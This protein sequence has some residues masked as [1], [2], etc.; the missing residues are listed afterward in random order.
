MTTAWVLGSGGL[1][2]TALCRALRGQRVALFVPAERFCWGDCAVLDLQIASAMRG[3]A[4][5]INAGD[6]WQIYWAAGI[7]TMGST[8]EAVSTETRALK[9]LLQ[10][11]ESYPHLLSGSGAIA[12]A[13]SAGAVYAGA[14]DAVIT[15]NTSA[16]P[17]T[18][19]ACE[20]V[21]QESL[22]S[23][24]TAANNRIGA[25]LARISTIYGPGQAVDKKQ[26]LL[27]HIARRILRNQPIQIFV[28]YDTIRDYI[29]VDDA[30]NLIVN[31]LGVAALRRRAVIKIIASEH[32]TTIAEIVSVFKRLA[33]RAP[34]I[35]TSA[36]KLSGL[37][38]RRVEFRSIALPECARVPRKS[39]LI[40][41]AQL[42]A[43]ERAAFVQSRVS[44]ALLRKT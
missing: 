20:K 41:I 32:P 23:T 4:A 43:A 36:S 5:K 34:R 33:R 40:G 3:F 25:L 15:E 24:F 35:V 31:A 10:L 1:L 37:Y 7:G 26:G 44:N 12:L 42:M 18:A 38:A 6:S 9:L 28:P 17:T 27:T 16:A 30:A 11:I 21:V 8:L 14:D 19:Y 22:I 13:S 39:L 2:G 29:A